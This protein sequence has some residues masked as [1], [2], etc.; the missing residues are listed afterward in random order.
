MEN[1]KAIIVVYGTANTGET[2][3]VK[4]LVNL[5]GGSVQSRTA[6]ILVPYKN[7]NVFVAYHGDSP[8]DVSRYINDFN[9]QENIDIMVCTTRTKGA[10][11]TLLN[12]F[13]TQHST[14]KTLVVWF[15][16]LAMA[17]A[18]DKKSQDIQNKKVA[19]EIKKMIDNAIKI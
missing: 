18:T 9:K 3:S 17:N 14:T 6:D 10:G 2:S 5:L 12:N 1:L 15:P 13:V 19:N 16:K 7:N 11:R 4:E 8:A